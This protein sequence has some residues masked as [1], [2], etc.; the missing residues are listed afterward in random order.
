MPRNPRCVPP[1]VTHHVTQRGVNRCDVFHSQQDREIY[2]RL[3]EANIRDAGV[4]VL[5]YCLMTNHVHWVVIPERE[6]SLAVLFRRVHGPYAQY[7]NARR[8]RSGHLWQNRFYSCAVARE[9]EDVVLKYAEWNPVRAG[10]TDTPA[11]YRWSSAAAHL[12]GPRSE[13]IALID[14]EYWAERG[15]AAWWREHIAGRE[16]T[17]DAVRVRRATYA[18]APLGPTSFVEKMEQQFGRHWRKPGRPAKKGSSSETGTELA[19]SVS[20]G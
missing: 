15:G 16:E 20:A 4:R 1:G 12:T 10:M 5:A 13:R 11:A 6:E 17:G 2:L 3:V 19:A 14:W 9:R 8:Q 18:G 7:L